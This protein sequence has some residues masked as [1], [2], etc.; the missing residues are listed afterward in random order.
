MEAKALESQIVEAQKA[1][2]QARTGLMAAYQANDTTQITEFE[3]FVEHAKKL[4]A[5]AELARDKAIEEGL[6]GEREAL[7]IAIFEAIKD[8]SVN[9]KKLKVQLEAVKATGFAFK[10]PDGQ[11]DT[12]RVALTVP[13]IPGTHKASSGNGGNRGEMQAKFGVTLD[14]AYNAFKEPEDEALFNAAELLETK[15]RNSKQ[16]TIKNAV[17]N[18]AIADGRLRPTS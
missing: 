13:G 16:W 5:M 10:L 2:T 4:V 7:G 9:G 8:V 17:R 1:L 18:R 3:G 11:S 6:A 14:Q 12:A 15:P